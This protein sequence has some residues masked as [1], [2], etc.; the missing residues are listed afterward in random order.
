MQKPLVA[1]DNLKKHFVI[2]ES[3]LARYLAGAKNR[4]VKAVDGVSIEILPGETLGLVGESGCGKST[5]GRTI[6][7]LYEPTEGDVQ[8]QG[9]SLFGDDSIPERDLRKQA[10][11][12]FQNPYSSLNPRHTVRQIIGVALALRGVPPHDREEETVSLLM[13]VGLSH[14]HIDRYPHQ[15]SGGQ[16]QRIGIA[17][18]LATNPK[19][20]VA[21]EPLS[22]LDVSVQAQIINL[23]QELQEDYGLT[24]LFITHDL[25]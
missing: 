1:T 17:R 11:I 12:I 9:K 16:R 2:E 23:L 19:F 4:V 13:R 15:F 18:A 5:L 24:Y 22:S 21:D 20:I 7:G 6:V 25:R 10:Q 3:L 8:F 14:D